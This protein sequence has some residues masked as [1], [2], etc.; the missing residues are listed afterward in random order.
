MY[1]KIH[2]LLQSSCNFVLSMIVDA[3]VPCY[4]FSQ[5][6][7]PSSPPLASSPTPSLPPSLSPPRVY[8]RACTDEQGGALLS[9]PSNLSSNF[10]SRGSILVRRRSL[11]NRTSLHARH[12]A[13]G[14][15]LKCRHF[16]CLVAVGVL[17]S[18]CLFCV[19]PCVS[20]CWPVRRGGAQT[21]AP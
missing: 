5:A 21:A 6:S 8:V 3:H 2:Q 12:A 13:A 20:C 7:L 9:S 11:A 19:Y 15:A 16:E 14:N 18:V 4:C 1:V 10:R 17:T